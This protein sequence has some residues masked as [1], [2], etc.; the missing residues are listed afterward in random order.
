MEEENDSQGRQAGRRQD[1]GV[2]GRQWAWATGIWG[3]GVM[4]HVSV[5]H[6]SPSPT[7]LIIMYAK[8]GGKLIMCLLSNSIPTTIFFFSSYSISLGQGLFASPIPIS[9]IF[10]L[11]SYLNSSSMLL[12]LVY[13][14]IFSHTC[15]GFFV[16]CLACL[17]HALPFQMFQ[18]LV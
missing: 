6:L 1:R 18:F 15:G 3:S 7:I 17:P 10:I 16:T 11:S 5:Q 8:N 2:M 4:F 9:G 12:D 13:A 14:F